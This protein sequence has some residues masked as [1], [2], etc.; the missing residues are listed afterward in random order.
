[1]KYNVSQMPAAA[2]QAKFFIMS[3]HKVGFNHQLLVE[4]SL[5]GLELFVGC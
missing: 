1:M 4:C 2:L 5:S 3:S